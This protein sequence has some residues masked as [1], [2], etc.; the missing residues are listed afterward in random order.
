[1][2]VYPDCTPASKHS[3]KHSWRQSRSW[4]RHVLYKE[5]VCIP[6]ATRGVGALILLTCLRG[7]SLQGRQLVELSTGS[8]MDFKGMATGLPRPFS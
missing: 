2:H 6:L 8:W 4:P 1:M 5:L 7:Q 3:S